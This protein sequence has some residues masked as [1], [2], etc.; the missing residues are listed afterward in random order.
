MQSE[1]K[2]ERKHCSIVMR[3]SFNPAMF[4]PE[5]FCRNGILS[6]EEVDYA[7]SQENSPIIIT[8]QV[9]MFRT[10]QLEVKI[11]M[12]RF[13]VISDKE[14]HLIIKDFITK[15]LDNIGNYQITAYG[16]NFAAHFHIEDK[17]V[18][19]LI[20]DRLAPKKYWEK[21]LGDEVSGDERKSGLLT[22]DMKKERETGYT[23]VRFQPSFQIQPGVFISCNEHFNI[24]DEDSSAIYVMNKIDDEFDSV[25]KKMGDYQIDL[26]KA[27][28]ASEESDYA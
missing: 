28:T 20:W 26:L 3:G 24:D 10:S 19:Q 4:Q 14:P 5:W 17:H 18:Y 9:S 22:L 27:L 23:P 6:V 25:I 2:P 1:F 13:E 21:L 12:D 15:T 8:P 16:I 7:R 11:E